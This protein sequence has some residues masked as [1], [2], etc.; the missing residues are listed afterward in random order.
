[1]PEAFR[2]ADASLIV[3]A[4]V[5]AEALDDA[6]WVRGLWWS[7]EQ[8]AQRMLA[9]RNAEGLIVSPALTG[10]S[11]ERSWSTNWWD[12]ICFGHLDAHSNALNYRALRLLPTLCRMAGA[13][14]AV[15]AEYRRAAAQLHR[16]YFPTFYN[17]ATGWLGGWRSKDG[18]L[19]DHGFL[20]INGIAICYG[21]V[22]P[23]Q[24][25]PTLEKLERQRV[26]VGFDVFQYGLPGNLLPVPRCDSVL[27]MR[28]GDHPA[29]GTGRYEEYQNGGVMMSMAHHYVRALGI[30]GMPIAEEMGS[31]MLE[32]FE[33]RQV[34]NPIHS[35]LDM[36]RWDGTGC[37]YE[38]VLTDEYY[39]LLA[40]AQNRGLVP[41]LNLGEAP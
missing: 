23:E 38:G 21:L 6:A 27:G 22:P 14:A 36:R 18:Q 37:G 19:H 32:S 25:R 9:A 7:I 39:V 29:D 4:A 26:A 15:A 10:N 8:A 12:V 31:A 13:P 28:D 35:G 5:L 33:A 34:L 1:V 2:D 40:I 16:A 24:V 30:A 11:G 3:A 20:F 41:G 17:P